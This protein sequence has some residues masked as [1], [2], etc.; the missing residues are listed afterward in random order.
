MDTY[1]M[2]SIGQMPEWEW[3]MVG[4]GDSHHSFAFCGL[5]ADVSHHT[6]SETMVAVPINPNF[7]TNI[8]RKGEKGKINDA[9]AENLIQLLEQIELLI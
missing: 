5:I 4:N 7:M 3:G 6:I 1:I 2:Y 8:I 9:D